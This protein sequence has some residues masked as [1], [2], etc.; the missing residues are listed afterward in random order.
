MKRELRDFMVNNPPEFVRERVVAML[1]HLAD[2]E[3]SNRHGQHMSPSMYK[4]HSFLKKSKARMQVAMGAKEAYLAGSDEYRDVRLSDYVVHF[5]PE[6]AAAAA[7][8]PGEVAVGSVEVWDGSTSPSGVSGG[9]GGSDA[10]GGESE[11]PKGTFANGRGPPRSAPLRETLKARILVTNERRWDAQVMFRSLVPHPEMSAM[12]LVE[13][14]SLI[15]RKGH[16]EWVTLVLHLYMPDKDVVS[17]VACEVTGGATT[18]IAALAHSDPGVFGV[19]LSE[20]EFCDDD[21]LHVPCVLPTLAGYLYD[22][23]GLESPGI[24]RIQP[25]H[26]EMFRIKAELGR[27]TFKTCKDINCVAH[28]IKVWYRELATP[29]LATIPN[30]VMMSVN[31]EASAIRVARMLKSREQHLLKWIVRLLVRVADNED[32]NKMNVKNC[33]IVVGPNLFNVHE[34]ANPMEALMMSQHVVGF[35]HRLLV[36]EQAGRFAKNSFDARGGDDVVAAVDAAGSAARAAPARAGIPTM[37]VS[38]S[39]LGSPGARSSAAAAAPV[40]SP[41]PPRSPKTSGG[42]A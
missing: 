5:G 15:V 6:H 23:G 39:A 3:R 8:S 24:F 18:Y 35:L 33:A 26:D 25:D 28:L 14:Q 29:I 41:P 36:A 1:D 32:K 9:A 31:D 22:H 21:G 37:G 17:L 11:R 27:G 38:R 16:P 30:E 19:P 10:A 40:P 20:V 2:R 13:P 7:K 4:A 12:M 34:K 42:D